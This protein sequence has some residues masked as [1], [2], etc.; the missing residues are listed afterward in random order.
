[1]RLRQEFFFL[2]FH[3]LLDHVFFLEWNFYNVWRVR[4]NTQ[5]I[6]QFYASRKVLKSVVMPLGNREINAIRRKYKKI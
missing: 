1:M 2:L 5:L 3:N 6:S 4:K